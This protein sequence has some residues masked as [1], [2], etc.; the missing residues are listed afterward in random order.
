MVF[1]MVFHGLSYDFI[2]LIPRGSPVPRVPRVPRVMHQSPRRRGQQP[3]SLGRPET[4]ILK[5]FHVDLPQD[6]NGR[7]VGFNGRLMG[8]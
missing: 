7:L 3:G 6:I 8:D 4:L 2:W 5:G 1:P